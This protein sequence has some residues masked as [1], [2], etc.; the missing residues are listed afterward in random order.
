MRN[1]RRLL[2]IVSHAPDVVRDG[3]GHW[4]RIYL[5][6]GRAGARQPWRIR[7]FLPMGADERPC[8]DQ[9]GDD[10]GKQDGAA[11]GGQTATILT[12]HF[13]KSVCFEMGSVASSVT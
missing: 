1:D 5:G 9:R 12:A 6:R 13:L 7:Q 8:P 10:A 2:G 3:A 11:P 4:R